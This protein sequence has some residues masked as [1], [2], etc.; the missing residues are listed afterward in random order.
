MS[1]EN[2]LSEDTRKQIVDDFSN[3]FKK[4]ENYSVFNS[5]EIKTS[6]AKLDQ[7]IQKAVVN[8]YNSNYSQLNVLDFE[9]KKSSTNYPDN[10]SKVTTTNIDNY[11]TKTTSNNL[12]VINNEE[13]VD[14]SNL[15]IDKIWNNFVKTE[16][17]KVVEEIDNSSSINQATTKIDQIQN[18][19][20]STTNNFSEVNYKNETNN[21]SNQNNLTNQNNQNYY[22]INNEYK[23]DSKNPNVINKEI[24][25]QENTQI[26]VSEI[27]QTIFE[28]IETRLKTYNVT[29]EDIILLKQK[30]IVEVTEYYEKKSYEQNLKIEQK[31]KK[32]VEDMFVRF[33]NT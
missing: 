25:I 31:L 17:E 22:S 2:V 3:E 33:L 1:V 16:I 26:N 28:K 6:Q 14:V 13:D 9:T 29:Q 12:Q 15:R 10:V 19:Y 30:I 23:V 4:S 20:S 18:D 7:A 21:F 27:T 24:N 32:D 5:I 8:T 11:E